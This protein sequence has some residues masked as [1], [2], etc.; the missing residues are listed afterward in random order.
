VVGLV[1]GE[2]GTP[3]AAE[4]RDREQ[5]R[6]ARGPQARPYVGA[7]AVD[8]DPERDVV[9]AAQHVDLVGV[10]PVEPLAGG[11]AHQGRGVAG[12]GEGGEGALAHDD[13]VDELDG[14]V[15][16]VGGAG[17]VAENQ[18]PPTSGEPVGH[19]A[20]GHAQ[21]LGLLGQ[22]LDRRGTA[23]E[24]GS[25]VVLQRRAEHG[26]DSSPT[27]RTGPFGTLRRCRGGRSRTGAGGRLMRTTGPNPASRRNW[28][29]DHPSVPGRQRPHRSTADRSGLHQERRL[30]AP[31]LYLSGYLEIQRREYYGRLQAVGERGEIQQ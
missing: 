5:A 18:Q 17:A 6:R 8:R 9:G 25:D 12:E 22:R 27:A 24:R 11:D 20:A 30:T 1:L 15:L 21:R 26:H 19:V 23:R 3:V 31:L 10:D 2:H 13:R 14:D 7:V 28:V 16:G 4:E 29:R